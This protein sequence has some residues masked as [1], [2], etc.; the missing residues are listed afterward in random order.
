ML[1][2]KTRGLE[3][4]KEGLGLEGHDRSN[5]EEIHT[6]QLSELRLVLRDHRRRHKSTYHRQ[7]RNVPQKQRKQSMIWDGIKEW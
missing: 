4:T 3:G 2:E 7:W 6:N 1:I 5:Q